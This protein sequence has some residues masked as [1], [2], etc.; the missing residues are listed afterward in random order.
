M[1]RRGASSADEW[2]AIALKFAAPVTEVINLIGAGNEIS[3]GAV[4]DRALH[5]SEGLTLI[6]RTKL[7]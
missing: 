6:K 7:R 4:E 1:R 5:A 2:G 3:A